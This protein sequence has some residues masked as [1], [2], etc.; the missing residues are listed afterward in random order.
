MGE[1]VL[2][3]LIGGGFSVVVALIHRLMKENRIDHGIVATSLD[4]IEDKI[5]R[6][7]ENHE[8]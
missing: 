5:D 6:H 3:A 1:G 8:R 2:V 7:I 4:R